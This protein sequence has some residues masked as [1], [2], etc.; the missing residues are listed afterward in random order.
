MQ[1]ETNRLTSLLITVFSYIVLNLVGI[2][3]G[4]DCPQT[5]EDLIISVTDFDPAPAPGEPEMSVTGLFDFVE[6][7]GI[8]S[9]RDLLSALPDH[10]NKN[11]ALVETTRTPGLASLEFPRIILFG[12]ESR[13]MMNV[14]TDP[15]DPDYERLDVSYMNKDTGNWEFA[16]FDFTTSPASLNANPASCTQCH[17]NPA[18]PLWG[19][20]LN[21][22]G[23]IGDDPAPGNQA[24]TL[25]A[26]HAQRFNE[27][28]AG[29]G[30]PERFHTLK[31]DNEYKANGAQHLPDHVYGF[32]LTISNME[33]G[34]TAAESVYLRMKTNF[35]QQFQTLREELLLLGYFDKRTNLL[36]STERGQIEDLIGH[37]GGQGDTVDDL[38]AVLGIDADNEFSLH[39]LT[40]E[41]PDQNWNVSSADLDELVYFLVLHD[42]VESDPEVGQILASV[43]IGQ[44]VEGI[45]T[46][47]DLGE[48]TLDVLKYKYTQGWKLKGVPRQELHE[49]FFG[50]D[51][52]RMNQPIFDRVANPLYAYL[53]T[54]ISSTDEL[55]GSGNTNIR[56]TFTSDPINE[57]D[58][59]VG[60]NYSRSLA[61]NASDGDG[62]TLTFSK[63]NGPGWLSVSSNGMLSGTPAIE[64][65]GA[66]TFIVRVTDGMLTDSATLNITVITDSDNPTYC[67]SKGN[68]TEEEWIA[69]VQIGNLDNS[70]GADS[71]GYH[72]F[73]S[74]NT[75]LAISQNVSVTLTP[76]Y[77][78]TNYEE[79][80][81]VW[82]DL[83]GDGDFGDTGENVFDPGV[84]AVGA[85]SG[86]LTVPGG[87]APQTTRMRVS[88]KYQVAASA[89]ES[90]TYGEVEDYT[91]TLEN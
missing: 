47:P 79:Y 56:P 3:H 54:K 49:T 63:I 18:R 6:T 50:L 4:Y 12:S 65:T 23:V 66:N 75:T 38:F 62:D 8:S 76:G 1:K 36:T 48:T 55:D 37:L 25:T 17:G 87:T 22:P 85:T 26:A 14:A 9:I 74:I 33:L 69:R 72:D 34:F 45:W 68:T 46:C 84:A 13:F 31:W 60:Q 32:A 88:M 51:V 27:L 40:T 70:S 28:K 2:V 57:V 64:D 73:T 77:S 20:Y 71:S 30:N 21:W 35:P 86:T 52:D 82:I 90:F 41:Q 58:A 39:K 91:V 81:M 67:D 44:G 19:T 53:R 29:F 5:P 61:G 89:C 42:L 11:Y 83:N 16:R 10:Y 43:P 80:F 59:N 7:N 24:E 78:G 15:D